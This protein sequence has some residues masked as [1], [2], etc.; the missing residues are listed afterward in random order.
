MTLHAHSIS[1]V[2]ID[3][4]RKMVFSHSKETWSRT[5]A[6]KLGK[7]P[8]RWFGHD[9][10]LGNSSMYF[11]LVVDPWADKRWRKYS[12]TMAEENLGIPPE[13]VDNVAWENL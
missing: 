10:H 11:Q 8:V 5:T 12:S 1:T 7:E 2:A 9:G 3:L 13:E 4:T 6:P